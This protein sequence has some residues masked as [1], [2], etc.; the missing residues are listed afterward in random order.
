M[1]LEVASV[2]GNCTC[3]HASTARGLRVSGRLFPAVQQLVLKIYN[4]SLQDYSE[5]YLEAFLICSI[6]GTA[7]P[8]GAAETFRLMGDASVV[9]M[10]G[11]CPGAEFLP[12]SFSDSPCL[13]GSGVAP[14][15]L[16]KK[17]QLVLKER[18]K[19]YNTCDKV[20][21]IAYG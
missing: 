8:L 7:S 9:A 19:W 17:D 6:V 13:G 15:A 3:V 16:L 11:D 18:T 1:V 21:C 2:G 20:T 4:K 14:T 10:G 5:T 12:P